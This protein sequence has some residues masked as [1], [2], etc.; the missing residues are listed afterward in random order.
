MS[1]MELPCPPTPAIR[2]GF[3]GDLL[4]LGALPANEAKKSQ[5]TRDVGGLEAL[6]KQGETARARAL[7][8]AIWSEL[9]AYEGWGDS[10]WGI[11]GPS[12]KT[13]LDLR[14]RV[15]AATKEIVFQ[16]GRSVRPEAPKSLAWE[17]TKEYGAVA[18]RAPEIMA[19]E[20]ARRASAA[21]GAAGDLLER[22]KKRL[23]FGLAAVAAVGLG[24]LW[25]YGYARGRGARANPRRRRR[26]P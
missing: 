21:A 10:S 20:A 1:Y 6:V 5:L 4:D 8:N 18:A 23:G 24:G 9:D 26:R 3:L 25:I 19:E 14:A 17:T 16:E 11:F 13:S 2:G 15:N 12:W 22:E 7:R